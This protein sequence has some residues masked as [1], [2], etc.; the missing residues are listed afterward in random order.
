MPN[1]DLY[2]QYKIS[3]YRNWSLYLT[4][5]KII[6]VSG[7]AFSG[8]YP[9][10]L[11]LSFNELT[12]LPEVSKYSFRIK[13]N[14]KN[15][16]LPLLLI[17]I[18]IVCRYLLIF[19]FSFKESFKSVLEN[20]S[21]SNNAVKPHIDVTGNPLECDCKI[22]WLATNEKLMNLV[23]GAKCTNGDANGL[24]IEELPEDFF[25]GC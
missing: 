19:D 14:K 12:S 6:E 22:Q 13:Y 11:Y 16:F 7:S 1:L 8:T 5:N 4:N 10:S 17:F 23:T 15:N 3:K 24:G 18:K 2:S 21:A 25:D 9:S 20:M